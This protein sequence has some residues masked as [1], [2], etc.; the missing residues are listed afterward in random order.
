[1]NEVS[2]PTENI[3]VNTRN[4]YPNLNHPFWENQYWTKRPV[5]YC[6]TGPAI[7]NR[8]S[9]ILKETRNLNTFKHKMKHSYLN[10]LSY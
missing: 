5:F 7:E 9:N 1:M 2:R 8:L 10:D 6:Y 4:S 3:R